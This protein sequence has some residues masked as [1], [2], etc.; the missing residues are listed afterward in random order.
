MRARTFNVL[1]LLVIVSVG[2][3]TYIVSRSVEDPRFT[4]IGQPVFPGLIDQVNNI[5]ELNIVSSKGSITVRRTD[6]SWRVV[7]SRDHPADPKEVFKA[8]VGIAELKYFEPKTERKEKLARLRLDDP[9]KPGSRS[10]RVILKIGDRIVADVVVGREK[11]FLPGLTVGGVYFRL[12]QGSESWLARGNPE[13][14]GL[15]KDWLAREI[16]NIDAKRVKSVT[17]RHDDN[18]IVQVSKPKIGAPKFVLSDMPAGMKVKYPS[19]LEILGAILERLEMDDARH[20]AD[21]TIDWN[22]S[23]VAEVETFDGI[24]VFLETVN[25]NGI[26]WLR[27]KLEAFSLETQKEVRDIIK[28][29]AGWVYMMPR[30][31]VVPIQ[32]RMRDLLIPEDAPS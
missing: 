13:A 18:D 20:V 1:I 6:K 14:G 11:L 24:R 31:E 25:R 32:R 10:K 9:T 5:T 17:I 19:D 2:A 22:G 12:P 21:Q 23:I 7:E 26:D 4:K 30:Y 27:I 3:A 16:V 29:T 8:I 15:P 28:R